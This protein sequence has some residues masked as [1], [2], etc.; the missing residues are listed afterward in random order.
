MLLCCRRCTVRFSTDRTVGDYSHDTGIFIAATDLYLEMGAGLDV[1]LEPMGWLKPGEGRL[2]DIGANIGFISDYVEVALGWKAKGYDPSRASELGRQWLGLDIVPDYFTEDTPLPVTYD[3]VAAFELL[4]HVPNPVPLLKTLSRGLNDTGILVLTTPDGGVLKPETP[5]SMMWPIISPGSHM[6]LFTATSMETALQAAGFTHVSVKPVAGILRIHASRMPLPENVA[7]GADRELLREYLRR[8]LTPERMPKYDRLE[9]GFRYRL[10]KELVNFGFPDEAQAVFE[11]IVRQVRARFGIDLDDPESLV[12]PPNPVNL[13]KFTAREPSNL[14]ATLHFKSILVNNRDNDAA[15]SACY[16]AAAALAGVTLRR[17]LQRLSMDN[18]EAGTAIPAALRLALQNLAVQGADIRPLLTLIEATDDTTGFML[19]QTDRE[20]LRPDMK[21]ILGTLG[22]PEAE[23]LDE[24]GTTVPGDDCITRLIML[25]RPGMCDSTRKA[26]VAALKA[27]PTAATVEALLKQ[28]VNDPVLRDW[29]A[30][31]ALCARVAV[32]RLIAL[33]LEACFGQDLA[34]LNSLPVPTSSGA[35]LPYTGEDPSDLMLAL[36]SKAIQANVT[37]NS[38]EQSA[39]YAAAAVLAGVTAREARHRLGVDEGEAGSII[40]AALRLALQNL[41]VDGADIRPLLTLIETADDATG[42]RL[43][44][45]DRESLRPT[46]QATLGTLGMREAETLDKKGAVAPGDDCVTR[47]ITLARPSVRHAAQEAAIARLQV[48]PTAA[49][50][51]SLLNQA[52]EDPALRDWP[53]TRALC[54]RVAVTRLMA[55]QLDA[56]FGPDLAPLESLPVPSASGAP[57]PYTAED[58]SDLMLALQARAIQANIAGNDAEQSACYAAAAVLAGVTA[59]EAR[60]RLD[61]DEGQAGTIIPAALRLAL[62]NLAVDGA[63]IRPLLTLIETAD[64]TDGFMLSQAERDSLRSD[65]KTVL[66][67][68]RLPQAGAL[69]ERGA[70]APGDDCLTRLITL[71]RPSVRHAAQEA[72]VAAAQAAETAHE[73]ETLLGRALDDPALRDWPAIRA[74]CARVAVTRLM[75]LQLDQRFGPD[76][77]PLAT[78]PVPA[79]GE[80]SRPYTARDPSDLML[81]LQ[82]RAIQANNIDNDAAQS[83]CYAAAAVLAGVTARQARHRRGL[84]EGEVGSV[85]PAALRL[86]LQNLAVLGADIRPVLT[87]AETAD[88]SDGFMLSQAERACL[89]S[90][91]KVLLSGLHLPTVATMDEK[92]VTR[93]GD[94]CLSRLITLTRPSVHPV[95][96]ERAIAALNSAR[97]AD[98]VQSLLEQAVKDS[99]L[100]D[101]PATLTVC[102]KVAV[103]RLVGLRAH[104]AAKEIFERWGDPSWHQDPPIAAALV[105]LAESRYPLIVRL[106]RRAW[107]KLAA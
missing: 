49:E 64:T 3:V 74:L 18:G 52:L 100:C 66:A 104:S 91:M 47:L 70:P 5:T 45:T 101:W 27:A 86:A 53:A 37:D 25:A 40:P 58:P 90:D 16:A 29:P 32:A 33:R 73:V 85:I 105:L 23:T 97:T 19:S 61:V 38:A 50:V 24:K 87:L 107:R 30:T 48:A 43:D 103:I 2:L 106:A 68:L 81:A 6:T 54:A 93:P 46:M 71:A 102:A 9:N 12:V 57:L 41:A 14:M 82:A 78:L 72:M 75:T 84:P 79:G 60:H 7:D 35:S 28:A 39:C 94:D 63:D 42:F 88:D 31:R 4:E 26:T 1:M 76:I 10:F 15:Q 8:R 95:A 13:E 65:M 21:A 36:Q 98:Q 51:E 89:R 77:A 69:D 83:A 59:R 99:A 92:G 67:N 11:Q 62:Q 17:V 20:S 55:L 80:T 22:M 34:P 44:Q 96:R 56:R